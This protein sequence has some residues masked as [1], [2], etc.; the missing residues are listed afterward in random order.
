MNI[1]HKSGKIIK[2][3]LFIP[4]N[5]QT[6]HG[7]DTHAE[8][9]RRSGS[10]TY[11][12]SCH[13]IQS[14]YITDINGKIFYISAFPFVIGRLP[15]SEGTD[16]SLAGIPEI[17]GIHARILYENGTYCIE[18]CNSTNGTFICGNSSSSHEKRIKKA[19]LH[20][21]SEFRLYHSR[22]TFHTD[23]RAGQ[24]C[25]INQNDNYQ[26]AA[27]VPIEADTRNRYKS[28]ITDDS[29]KILSRLNGPA[30]FFDSKFLIETE[31]HRFFISSADN[32]EFIFED[33]KITPGEK[34][35]LFSGCRFSHTNTTYR[36]Y[37]KD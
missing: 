29:G 4:E 2:K 15:V 18:D 16:L 23:S 32:T 34:T 22:F 24:T 25:V 9:G 27:T 19:E 12:M 5:K 10:V 28:Y 21:G 33:E 20:D 3:F 17:S 36:F 31:N 14:A 11:D 7:N 13:E 6:V 8:A 1:I 35:E 37:I 26:T 30:D